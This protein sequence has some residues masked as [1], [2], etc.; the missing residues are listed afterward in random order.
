MSSETTQADLV[1]EYFIANPNRNIPHTEIVPWLMEEYLK[2]T[3]KL[4]RDPDRGIR[5]AHQEGKLIKVK[6]GEYRYNPDLV[7]KRELE[8]FT[9]EQK[10]QILERDNYRCVVCGM[11]EA[12]GLEVH[13]DHILPKDKG[14]EATIE[15]GQ[16]LCSVHNFRK[17]NYGQTESAKRYFI[18]ILGKARKL[19]DKSTEEFCEALLRV[20]DQFGVNGHIDWK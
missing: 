5:K 18:N 20:Y 3:G 2:R 8:D 13:V 12:N 6:K 17:K 14:G 19:K 9:P 4:F 11:G 1:M 10:R 15:N 16:V 7:L